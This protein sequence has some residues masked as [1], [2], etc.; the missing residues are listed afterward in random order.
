MLWNYKNFAAC[1]LCFLYVNILQCRFLILCV[2][3]NETLIN[4]ENSKRN[5]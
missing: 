2:I 3:V 5:M 4:L 1:T